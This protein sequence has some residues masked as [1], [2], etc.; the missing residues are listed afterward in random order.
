VETFMHRAR[1][2]SWFLAA[3]VATA[4]AAAPARAGFVPLPGDSP[5]PS[6]APTAAQATCTL[7]PGIRQNVSF[8]WTPPEELTSMAWK[9]P[10]CTACGPNAGLQPT[11]VTFGVRWFRPCTAQAQVRVV[12]AHLVNGCLA[13]DTTRILCAGSLQTLSAPVSG[14]QLHTLPF[15]AGC[16][17]SGDAFLFIRFTGFG[18]CTDFDATVSPGLAAAG[19]PCVGCDQYVS[20]ANIFPDITEWCSIG[21]SGPTWFSL[22]AN[23][24]AAT[25]VGVKSWGALKTLYR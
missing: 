14:L 1:L 11:Q 7:E 13:P 9:I 12:G 16:C 3:A 5:L 22:Q 8:I 19:G 17:I 6:L 24:C 10:T 20:A 4:G 15:A 23:C 2:L 21:A 18:K 25:G